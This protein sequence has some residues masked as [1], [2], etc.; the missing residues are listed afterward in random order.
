MEQQVELISVGRTIVATWQPHETAVLSA[1]RELGLE[2][3][4]IFNKGAVM[5]LP[6]GVTKATGL[7]MALDDLGIVPLNVVAVGDAENGLPHR[8][9][10]PP[11][12][13]GSEATVGAAESGSPIRRRRGAKES[14]DCR[15]TG[16]HS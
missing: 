7:R 5:I 8:R 15:C 16:W 3:H 9:G 6:A 13:R 12:K 10:P 11:N 4:I 1:I 2:L 14:Q